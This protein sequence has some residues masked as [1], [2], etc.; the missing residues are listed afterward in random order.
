MEQAKRG[1]KKLLKFYAS[2]T[3]KWSKTFEDSALV[4]VNMAKKEVVLNKPI[5][6][7]QAILDLSKVVM[8]N[9]HYDYVLK[10]WPGKV[11]LLATDTDSLMYEIR[12]SDFFRDINP[13]VKTH[14]DTSD[15]PKDHSSGILT[16]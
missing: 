4:S 16:G 13:D 15:Y 12:T 2:S 14:F 10:K 3:F 6:I 8:F 1:G 7:G 5:A 11:K 9:F